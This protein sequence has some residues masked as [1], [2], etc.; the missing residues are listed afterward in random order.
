[1][2][3][4]TDWSIGGHLP[5]RFLGVAMGLMLLATALA[6]REAAAEPV[7]PRQAMQTQAAVCEAL[8]GAAS[9]EQQQIAGSGIDVATKVTCRGGLL[10]GMTCTNA[11]V[12]DSSTCSMSLT[13]PDDGIEW[14]PIV[15][16]IPDL[17][18]VG[19]LPPSL[20]STL[21][22]TA[23]LAGLEAGLTPQEILPAVQVPPSGGHDVAPPHDTPTNPHLDT[24]KKRGHG[25]KHG[26]GRKH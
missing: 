26:K 15:G 7:N 2:N 13:Q 5:A 10:D 20:W 3:A 11:V 8:G 1:M 6:P 17:E 21:D 25:K 19:F 12:N 18:P 9:T 4:T 23:I 16:E 14:H 22:V 24:G